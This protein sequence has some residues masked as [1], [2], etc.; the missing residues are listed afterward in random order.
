MKSRIRVK[1]GH[2][3]VP[4]E[5]A[6]SLAPGSEL[7]LGAATDVHEDQHQT[8]VVTVHEVVLNHAPPRLSFCLANLGVPVAGKVH[9]VDD[10]ALGVGDAKPI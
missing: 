3:W 8:E 4:A 1:L 5:K 10:F 7:L 9:K 2:V 6:A